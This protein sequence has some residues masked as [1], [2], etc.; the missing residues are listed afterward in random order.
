MF[1]GSSITLTLLLFCVLF[2]Y[3]QCSVDKE[4]LEMWIVDACSILI[5]FVCLF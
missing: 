1:L 3:N 4:I 2:L 5:T